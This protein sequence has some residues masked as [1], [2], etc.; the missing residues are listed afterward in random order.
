MRISPVR[1]PQTRAVSRAARVRKVPLLCLLSESGVLAASPPPPYCYPGR[2]SGAT[3]FCSLARFP[4]YLW[5]QRLRIPRESEGMANM[6]AFQSTCTTEILIV[7]GA[8]DEGAAGACAVSLA[9]GSAALLSLPRKL[10]FPSSLLGRCRFISNVTASS[11]P[12]EHPPR[13]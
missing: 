7:A 6:S 13:H 9:H 8:A 4:P 12:R 11:C 2:P 5:L 1:L 3:G 10:P